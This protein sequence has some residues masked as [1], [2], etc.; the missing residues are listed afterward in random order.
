MID[1][2]TSVAAYVCEQYRGKSG[3]SRKCLVASTASPYKFAKSVMMAIDGKYEASD[4]L[5]L[6]DELHRVSGVDM[7][8]AIQ[9]ILDAKVIHTLECDTD[10]MQETVKALLKH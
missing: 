5:E 1:T 10:K 7:P 9:D 6:L 3:D 4:D 2:H 8:Q